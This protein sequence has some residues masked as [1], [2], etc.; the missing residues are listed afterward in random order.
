MPYC[1]TDIVTAFSSSSTTAT[2]ATLRSKNNAGT[3]ET[4]EMPM[5]P[6]QI[7]QYVPAP[8]EAVGYKITVRA[9]MLGTRADMWLR[10]GE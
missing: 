8:G 10:N 9:D 5:P 6:T 2:N 4:V 7:C 1:E 3:V